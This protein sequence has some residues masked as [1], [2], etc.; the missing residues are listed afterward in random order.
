MR[1][2]SDLADAVRRFE[3]SEGHLPV[4]IMRFPFCSEPS[5]LDRLMDGMPGPTF[6]TI[7]GL[8]FSSGKIGLDAYADALRQLR[9]LSADALLFAGTSP[10]SCYPETSRPVGS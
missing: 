8:P 7:I 9:S 3:E 10:R 2:N 1:G 5:G 4:P 6:D